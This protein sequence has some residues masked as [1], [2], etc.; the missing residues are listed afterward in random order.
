MAWLLDEAVA[1]MAAPLTPK[2]DTKMHAAGSEQRECAWE[3]GEAAADR[4]RWEKTESEYVGPEGIGNVG[5]K[6][7]RLDQRAERA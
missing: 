5:L 4:G 7:S 2:Q 1:E 6:R 3:Q